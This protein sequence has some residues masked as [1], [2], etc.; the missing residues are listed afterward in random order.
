MAGPVLT[1]SSTVTCPHGGTVTLTTSDTS[2]TAG[3]SPVLLVS[4][5]HQ[6]VGCPF[7]L[8]GGKYSPCV[9]VRWSA[10]SAQASAGGTALLVASSIGT[11]SNGEQAPQGLAISS[12]GQQAVMA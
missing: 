9:T 11:C 6:V 7:T 8:P 3:G 1:T 5:V 12:P 4:D 10:G 2:A